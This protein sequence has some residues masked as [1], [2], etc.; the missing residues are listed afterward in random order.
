MSDDDTIEI[1]DHLEELA[2]RLRRIVVAVFLATVLF[3]AIPSD[4]E[5]AIRL[6]FDG[7]T[8][9]VS[10]L[11][12]FIQD[13]MLPEGVIL[14]AF[15]W[16]DTFS[17]YVM[18]SVVMGIIITLPYTTYHLFQFISPALYESERR[19][20]YMFVAV[21]TVLFLVGVAYAWVI[22][23]PTT[24]NMLYRFV[25]TSRVMPMYSVADFF[26]IFT[27]GLMGSGLFYMFPLVIWL[28]V[29][30]DLIDVQTL[31]SSRKQLFV[32]L[33]IVTAFL[34]DPTPLTMFLMSVPFYVLYEITI[35]VLSRIM[36]QEKD[37]TIERG[38]AASKKLLDS[39][40]EPGGSVAPPG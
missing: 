14:I 35:Q 36:H 6:D 28:M 17:I 33:L 23:L 26:N 13:S 22:L 5:K 15:N 20:V 2:R 31:K 34:P 9:I 39:I 25:Y 37:D 38:L 21:A 10:T 11:I 24:F 19:T 3:S 4:L 30:V 7:Y 40:V 27:M 16:L 32:A 12:T 29:K 1:W 18:M 8:P